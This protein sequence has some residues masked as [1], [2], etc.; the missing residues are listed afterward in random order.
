MASEGLPTVDNSIRPAEWLR[1]HFAKAKETLFAFRMTPAYCHSRW[2]DD[3]LELR[4]ATALVE[5]DKL[6]RQQTADDAPPLP[7]PAARELQLLQQH[8]WD[9][10][11][12]SRSCFMSKTIL[13]S[14]GT[15]SGAS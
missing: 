9:L 2:P 13:Q 3:D 7:R 10:V 14:E 5:V 4:A 15:P 6:F 12:L 11:I 1:V 8:V